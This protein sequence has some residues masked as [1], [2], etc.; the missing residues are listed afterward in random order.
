LGRVVCWGVGTIGRARRLGW[1]RPGG[2]LGVLAWPGAWAGYVDGQP[3][4]MVYPGSAGCRKVAY[5]SV[6]GGGQQ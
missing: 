1:E 6:R 5:K 4:K 2:G 3:V